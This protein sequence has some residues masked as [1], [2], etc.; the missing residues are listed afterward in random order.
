MANWQFPQSDGLER[1]SMKLDALY[2]RLIALE[3][4][5][6][7]VDPMGEFVAKCS[8]EELDLMIEVL[9]A[10]EDNKEL[11]LAPEQDRTLAALQERMYAE[12]VITEENSQA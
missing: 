8:D 4:Q 10:Q 1:Y 5:I 11:E 2:R 12:G 9:N 3:A 7:P 6:K